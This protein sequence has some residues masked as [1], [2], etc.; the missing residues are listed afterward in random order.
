MAD[1][2]KRA[3][4]D[5]YQDYRYNE[6]LKQNEAL[7]AKILDLWGELDEMTRKYKMVVNNNRIKDM[8][9]VRL[10]KIYTEEEY[11]N[12]YIE[13]YQYLNHR[14]QK[15]EQIKMKREDYKQLERK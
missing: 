14:Y 2:D 8:W 5:E 3:L 9:Q 4:E 10:I 12:A 6:L 1:L 13:W 11:I 15:K 7:K